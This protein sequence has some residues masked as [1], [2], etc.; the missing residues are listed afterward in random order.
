MKWRQEG[1]HVSVSDQGYK[2]SKSMVAGKPVFRPS[3]GGCFIG[4][5]FDDS[6]LASKVCEQHFKEAEK[7]KK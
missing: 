3:K 4:G 2:V 5:V 7:A 6:A 1:P